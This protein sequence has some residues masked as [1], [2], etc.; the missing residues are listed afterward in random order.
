VRF[1]FYRQTGG[2]TI[3][4]ELATAL[5]NRNGTLEK[6]WGNDWAPAKVTEPIQA[7]SK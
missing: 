5:I 6:I 3:S 7:G 2:G 4:H 1:P